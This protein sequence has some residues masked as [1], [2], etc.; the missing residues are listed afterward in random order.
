MKYTSRIEILILSAFI[1]IMILWATFIIMDWSMALY[2][3]ISLV[4]TIASTLYAIHIKKRSNPN[5]SGC[6]QPMTLRN[7]TLLDQSE[8]IKRGKFVF[9]NSNYQCEMCQHNTYKRIL[10]NTNQLPIRKLI[11]K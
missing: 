6:G 7:F 5:C 9:L 11:K 3:V 1:F 10:T 4:I 8:K 2:I